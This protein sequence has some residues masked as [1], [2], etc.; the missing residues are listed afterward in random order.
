MVVRNRSKH[1]IMCSIRS[2]F[3]GPTSLQKAHIACTHLQARRHRWHKIHLPRPLRRQPSA[4]SEPAVGCCGAGR[5]PPGALL[6]PLGCHPSPS[7]EAG[8]SKSRVEANMRRWQG[9]GVD[10]HNPDHVSAYLLARQT[11]ERP[12][13]QH[14]LNII[15]G[16]TTA[17]VKKI[18]LLPVSTWCRA[19][20]RTVTPLGRRSG[21]F[22][23]KSFANR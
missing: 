17:A 12:K 18:V 3:P 23:R 10:P 14:V 5:R 19:H 20:P 16:K 22:L 13:L 6:R 21:Q 9:K 2:C 4:S 7:M 8:L 1:F 15:N 11:S